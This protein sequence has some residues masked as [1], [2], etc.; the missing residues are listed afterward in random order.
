MKMLAL[1]SAMN[2]AFMVLSHG[3]LESSGKKSFSNYLAETAVAFLAVAL[4][5]V[6]AW[7]FRHLLDA[8][9]IKTF[10]LLGIIWI[11][12]K[13]GEWATIIASAFSILAFTFFYVEPIFS[14]SQKDVEYLVSFS[15]FLLVGLLVH[16]LTSRLKSTI[17]QLESNNANLDARVKEELEKNR[18][19]DLIVIEQSRY[20]AIGEVLHNIAHHWR[21]PLT[22]L[23]MICANL[24]DA[25]QFNELDEKLID[26]SVSDSDRILKNLSATIDTFRNYLEQDQ[27]STAFM[28][29]EAIEG[30]I[31]LIHPA[32]DSAGIV[33]NFES[34]K[35]QD[36]ELTGS[37]ADLTQAL[38]A[39]LSNSRDAFL[40][41]NITNKRVSITVERIKEGAV[42]RITDNAGGIS[43]EILPRIFDP[44]FTAKQQGS[45]LGLFIAKMAV[46]KMGGNISVQN[47]NGAVEFSIQFQGSSAGS[48]PAGS[49]PPARK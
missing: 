33:I 11:A 26:Q 42:I 29:N 47:M 14:F 3:P 21:Q 19:K 34:D 24:K 1:F 10:Y 2:G 12:Y 18:T 48:P 20:L 5:T 49:Q 7:P 43:E 39:I 41:R 40:E 9:N 32:Y 22:A 46:E 4:I 13:D 25:Y 36:I 27:A 23:G 45:G 35:Q 37:S 44:Y 17:T 6:L 38:L 28:L 8:A 31:S 30:V 15:G 16:T